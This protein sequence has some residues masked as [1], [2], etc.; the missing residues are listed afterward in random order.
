MRVLSRASFLRPWGRRVATWSVVAAVV[1]ACATVATD[2]ATANIASVSITPPTTTVAIGAQ[3]PLQVLAQDPNGKT[4]SVTDVFWSVQDPSV[5]TISSTGVVTGVA[6]GSTQVAASVNGKSGIATIT[7]EKTPVASVVVTPPHVD[8]APGVKTPLLATAYD[9]AQNILPDRGIT[10]STSNAAVATVDASGMVTAVSQGSATI[11]GTSEGKSGVATITVTQSAVATVTVTP[12]PLS[13]SVGQTTQLVATLKDTVGNQLNGRV[14]TWASSSTTVATVA[15]DGTVTAVA[16]GNATITATSEGKSGAAALSVTNVAVGSV[17]VQP[18]GPSIVVGANVQLSATV[19]DVNGTVVTDRLVTWTSGNASLATVSS[20][21]VVTGVAAG[22]VT[23]TA[24]S[25]GKSGATTVNVMKVP[26]GSVTV[27]PASKN[28][29]VTQ[30]VALT[31]VVKDANGAVV[32]DRVVTWS[33]SNTSAATVSS[34]GVVTAVAAGSATITATSE[35]K[36]GTSAI[37][38][39]SV[40]VSTVLVQPARDTIFTN[41]SLQLTA[42]TEDSIGGVLTGRT[43]TWST[44][45]ATVAN[46]STTGLV[47]ASN[48]TGNAT[49]TATSEGKS[50]TSAITVLVPIASVT[51]A[52]STKTIVAGDTT[53]FT[54]TA[55]D[56][57]NN[58]ITGRTLLWSSSNPSVATVSTSGLATGTGLG[59]VTITATAPLE[60]K[61]GSA[62]LTVNAA[63]VSVTPNPD[64]AYLGGS[65]TLTAT[66]KDKNG[67]PIPVQG[68]AWSSTNSTIASVG[69][70]TGVV[71]A[72]KAGTA[73][74]VATL[75][76]APS[77]SATF[78]A[79][80]PVATVTILPPN[81]PPVLSINSSTTLTAALKDALG[82]AIGAGRVVT[83]TTT[84]TT[85]IV[86]ITPQA[87]PAYAA[88]IKGNKVGTVTIIVTSEQAPP[89]TVPIIVK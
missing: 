41:G 37:T 13:M 24:T 53:R 59:V 4:I 33:S 39:S 18:Q 68:F 50:G 57:S 79:Q 42:V 80:A 8:A 30:N 38:V 32:T 7:V 62:T 74:I 69:S 44:T 71:T 19:R 48:K 51:V 78:L 28:M 77:G 43:V 87:G 85:G 72:L 26:V 81:P 82:F 17:T 2:I 75:T 67:N 64:S 56:G 9:A 36:S 88:T 12:S 83:W 76:G 10:W 1:A 54:A 35:T 5:A 23:I 27:S 60:G 73:T 29:L 11:T 15:T 45:D 63:S 49:I 31:V 25:E 22:S 3:I 20:S 14:V 40:P 34:V 6:L 16:A 84:D 89:A 70:Q 47:T 65:A 86:T 55:K 58:V 61:S 52:P 21:G 46:V 66:A